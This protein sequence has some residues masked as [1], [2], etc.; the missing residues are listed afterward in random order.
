M[1]ISKLV[2]LTS[3]AWSLNILAL[4]H[5]GVPGRQAP[6]LAASGASRTSFNASLEH[7]TQL[8]FLEKNPGHGHP[9][10]PEFRLTSAGIKAAEIASRI[11]NAVPDER[12][13]ALLRKS[14]T[15]PILALTATPRRFSGIRSDLA[16]ITDRALS[17]SLVQLEEREWIQRD[18]DTS[19]RLP[20]PLYCATNTGIEINRAIDLHA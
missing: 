9:L 19:K 12:E 16:T 7:L 8:K 20:F 17:A 14:W 13:F 18:I 2:K 11:V 4:L 5:S 1:D 3:R 6:L 10:R 15:L